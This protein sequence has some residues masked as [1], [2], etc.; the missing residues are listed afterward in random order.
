MSRK[1]AA[2]HEKFAEPCG[3]PESGSQYSRHPEPLTSSSIAPR[4]RA[5][6]ARPRE[7]RHAVAEGDERRVPRPLMGI[8]PVRGDGRGALADG[9]PCA[10]PSAPL[11][12]LFLAI[13]REMEAVARVSRQNWS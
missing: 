6:S 13:S 7:V 12:G 5:A 8:E 4:M 10:P 1:S 2:V 9:A 11:S 3:S